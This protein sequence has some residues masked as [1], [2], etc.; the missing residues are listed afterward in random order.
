MFALSVRYLDGSTKRLRLAPQ[1]TLLEVRA[2]LEECLPPFHEIR[3]LQG[4]QELRDDNVIEVEVQALVSK[5]VTQALDTLEIEGKYLKGGW[6]SDQE[7]HVNN[8]KD[9]LA[10][11]AEVGSLDHSHCERLFAIIQNVVQKAVRHSLFL[12]FAR[13]FGRACINPIPFLQNLKCMDQQLIIAACSTMVMENLPEDFRQ[14]LAGQARMEIL[15]KTASEEEGLPYADPEKEIWPDVC[16]VLGRIGDCSDAPLLHELK[17]LVEPCH[18]EHVS[19]ALQL[20]RERHDGRDLA[21][22]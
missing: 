4:E 11:I 14:F 9:A 21:S 3:L 20:I 18:H 19:D 8:V 13:A 6:T 15:I 7:L 12:D 5:S 2:Q 16:H 22:F 17:L 1:S 10:F